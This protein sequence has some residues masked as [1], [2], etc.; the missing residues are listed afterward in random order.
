MRPG[1]DTVIRVKS[2]IH[3][4]KLGSKPGLRLR[5]V[6]EGPLSDQDARYVADYAKHYDY[7]SICIPNDCPAF[8]ISFLQYFPY[9]KDFD[10]LDWRFDQFDDLQFLPTGLE[11]LS[12]AKTR[13]K[14]LSLRFLEPYS[15]LKR[16]AIEDHQRDIAALSYLGALESLTLRSLTLPDLDVLRSL[17]SL[18]SLAIKLGGTKNLSALPGIGRLQ[19]LEVWLVR[20]LN[21][22]SVL[23][24]L[25]NLQYLK[26]QALRNVAHLP[27]FSRH[28]G[29]RRVVLDTMRG[30]LDLRPVAAAPN[31]EEIGIVSMSQLQPTALLPFVGHPHLRAAIVGLGSDKKNKAVQEMLNLP[32]KFEPFQFS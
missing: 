30:V 4:E 28:L 9:L 8:S 22:L 14:K 18:R 13:S 19:Y 23:T 26:L 3:Q 16:L 31:L 17:T 1:F 32:A 24:E 27:L 15:Q 29:L 5:V 6:V 20:G 25:Q 11:S 21:D 7:V 12:L 10:L 2:P